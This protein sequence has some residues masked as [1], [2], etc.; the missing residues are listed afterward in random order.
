MPDDTQTPLEE[1]LRRSCQEKTGPAQ[2]VCTCPRC[3]RRHYVYNTHRLKP[4]GDGTYVYLCES[5]F[6]ISCLRV[7]GGYTEHPKQMLLPGLLDT[8][9][10]L[11]GP[12]GGTK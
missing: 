1:M 12:G 10:L 2:R 6:R 4:Y 8:E 9:N 3:K 7:S 11:A 5:C